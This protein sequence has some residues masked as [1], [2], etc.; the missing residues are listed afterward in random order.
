METEVSEVNEITTRAVRPGDLSLILAT[1][2]RSYEETAW[3]QRF[4]KWEMYA[5]LNAIMPIVLD[6]CHIEV[7]CLKED[8]DVIIGWIALSKIRDHW[9]GNDAFTELVYGYVKPPFRGLGIFKMLTQRT[10]LK[11]CRFSAGVS[12]V[13]AFGERPS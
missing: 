6:K 4:A 9:P 10:G 3:G 8:P 1:W 11:D 13:L 12:K 7:A 5:I 2:K